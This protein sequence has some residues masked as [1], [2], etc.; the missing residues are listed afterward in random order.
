MLPLIYIYVYLV[1]LCNNNYGYISPKFSLSSLKVQLAFSICMSI[2]KSIILDIRKP[3]FRSSLF[4]VP[5]LLCDFGQFPY[6]HWTSLFS[7]LYVTLWE[8]SGSL[9]LCLVVILII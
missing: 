1:S 5:A 7:S 3:E 2:G 6:L 4:W 9:I 8:I